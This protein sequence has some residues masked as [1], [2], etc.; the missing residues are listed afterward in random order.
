MA[1]VSGLKAR[2]VTTIV[3]ALVFGSGVTTGLAWD[4][5]PEEARTGEQG[6]A[7]AQGGEQEAREHGDRSDRGQRP[8]LV[9]Q[10]GLTAEQKARV[11]EIVED[12][13]Q[14]MRSLEKDTRPQYR[15]IIEETRT[16]IKEVL[17]TEQRAEYE[18]ILSER[19]R[20]REERRR[21]R[22]NS[23]RDSGR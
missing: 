14:R 17:T 22:S 3:L 8:L 10:V 15:A 16:A 1:M 2:L 20:E 13:R 6:Q 23:S 11:Y 12:S 4:R 18:T 19:D 5:A 9:E 7:E 21:G